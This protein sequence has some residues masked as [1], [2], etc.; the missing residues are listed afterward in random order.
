MRNYLEKSSCSLSKDEC[1]SEP[2]FLGQVFQDSTKHHSR[3][4]L[5][6]PNLHLP[7]PLFVIGAYV[8]MCSSAE[9]WKANCNVGFIDDGVTLLISYFG[10]FGVDFVPGFLSLSQ[11]LLNRILL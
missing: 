5:A 3:L 11:S 2:T 7:I 1:F 9:R 6:S 4:P 8:D 10:G